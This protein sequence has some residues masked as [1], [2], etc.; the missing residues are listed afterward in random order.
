MRGEPVRLRAKR[1]ERGWGGVG[2]G[3]AGRGGARTW[4]V[5]SSERYGVKRSPRT[6]YK[7]TKQKTTAFLTSADALLKA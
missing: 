1:A 7:S 4:L 2:W 5:F 3:G 6:W